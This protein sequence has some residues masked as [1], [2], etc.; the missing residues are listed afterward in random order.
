MVSNP[1][2]VE[3]SVIEEDGGTRDDYVV[4]STHAYV[5]HDDGIIPM[6]LLVTQVVRAQK[7]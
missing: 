5:R 6:S 2:R 7:P 3:V 1:D 4:N